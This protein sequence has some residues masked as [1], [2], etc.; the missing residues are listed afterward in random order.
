MGQNPRLQ[1]AGRHEVQAARERL[2]AGNLS[3][4]ER[5]Q[6]QLI[7]R[8]HDRQ[9]RTLQLRRIG[10]AVA[11]ALATIAVAMALGVWPAIEAG[12]QTR[13]GRNI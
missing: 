8:S 13:R 2:A 1:H 9:G 4:A 12:A 10:L 6:L 5:R 7:I 3:H 11:G